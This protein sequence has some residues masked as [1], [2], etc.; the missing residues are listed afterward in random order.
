MSLAKAGA[1]SLLRRILISLAVANLATLAI[2]VLWFY[3][4]FESAAS[5]ISDSTVISRAEEII[6]A[7]AVNPDGSLSLA[8]PEAMKRVY[9]RSVTSPSVKGGG[10]S[11]R[12]PMETARRHRFSVKEGGGPPLFAS[13]FPT[14]TPPLRV[15]AGPFGSIYRY[16]DRSQQPSKMIGVARL[17][18][19]GGHS[20]LIQVEESTTRQEV[21]VQALT[22]QMFEEGVWL[23]LPI[24]LLPLFVSILAVRRSFRPV[25]ALSGQA[26]C[27]TPAAANVR[28]DE[29][30][31][32]S[33][34]LPLV[35]AC[36][37]AVERLAEGIRI[38][39]DFTAGA[40]HELRMPL[41]VFGAHLD[42]LADPSIK[43]ALRQDLDGITHV[44][45]QLL[46]AAQIEFQSVPAGEYTDLPTL[47]AE[48]VAF[49][50][51]LAIR[52]GK[53]I[54]L[55][56]HAGP[57]PIHGRAQI[58]HHA[59]T[60]LIANAIAHTAEGTEVTVSIGQTPE[61]IT[62]AIRDHGPGVLPEHRQ[63][64]FERFWRA[65]RSTTGS[66]LGLYIVKK[67]TEMHGGTVS[68]A[69]AEGG[70]AVFTLAFPCP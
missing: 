16:N 54:A 29:K 22:E 1:G 66:G 3:Q 46:R 31:T 39:Q 11:S 44:V 12:D 63:K 40:A 6:D 56:C 30:Q 43:A 4:R 20:L 53:S 23:A 28:L 69:G 65:D 42:S 68:V 25:A 60:N 10:K 14:G 50:A 37:L 18:T 19:V 41:A 21:L 67:A 57:P 45:D 59:I 34:L 8:L 35:R 47:A 7:I 32:P 13:T 58:L 38:Q 33:E 9:S 17:A 27:I 48:S 2:A 5:D 64:V 55:V 24:L 26:E 36:N 49:L 62:V 70:G 61:V 15:T 52:Q 51:P